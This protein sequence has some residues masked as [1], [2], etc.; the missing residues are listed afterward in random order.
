[1]QR[2]HSGASPF[3]PAQFP[4]IERVRDRL[5]KFSHPWVWSESAAGP[6]L[7]T[8][9]HKHGEFDNEEKTLESLAFIIAQGGS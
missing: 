5:G 8:L 6:G 9:S 7:N 1:M 4:E 3:D 2:Y